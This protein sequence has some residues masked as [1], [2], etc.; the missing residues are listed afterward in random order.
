MYET[1]LFLVEREIFVDMSYLEHVW[2]AALA[3]E[4]E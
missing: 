1:P 4:R 2:R 3:V